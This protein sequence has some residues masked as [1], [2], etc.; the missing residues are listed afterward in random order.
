MTVWRAQVHNCEETCFFYSFPQT[1]QGIQVIAGSEKF[2]FEKNLY[3]IC[4]Y[5]LL[6]HVALSIV[7][8]CNKSG[9][10][11]GCH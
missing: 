3:I 11:L 7:W 5:S 8:Y 4:I 1:N 9:T 2:T 6:Y 10:S